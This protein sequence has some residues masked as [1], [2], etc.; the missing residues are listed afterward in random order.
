M[1]SRPRDCHE[2]DGRADSLTV[3]DT[4]QYCLLIAMSTACPAPPHV[5]AGSCGWLISLHIVG[6]SRMY[7]DHHWIRCIFA[8]LSYEF[9]VATLP[10]NAA[11]R[12]VWAH[13]GV[14][15]CVCPVRAE[16]VLLLGGAPL[17]CCASAQTCSPAGLFREA[18]LCRGPSL[19]L[20]AGA[21]SMFG[22]SATMVACVRMEE[23]TD[24]VC[25]AS[26]LARLCTGSA[27]LL[28]GRPSALC[29]IGLAVGT[30]ITAVGSG[31][32]V[33]DLV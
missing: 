8:G 32:A 7:V 28:R 24:W 13:P 4:C 21:L 12:T 22:S 3:K 29:A 17:L 19:L 11:M 15:C 20:G 23:P 1:K 25:W 26:A 27:D 6:F 2:E 16:A 30:R 9:S 5:P 31:L 18:R 33:R 14:L 10:G